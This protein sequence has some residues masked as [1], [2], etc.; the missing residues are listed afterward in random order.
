MSDAI[1]FGTAL[2]R[3]EFGHYVGSVAFNHDAKTYRWWY[4]GQ[5][6]GG[7]I[8]GHSDTMEAAHA[9][10]LAQESAERSKPRS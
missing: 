2:V 7:K 8:R 6:G 5:Y 4:Y 10:V 1:R 3:N 9:N